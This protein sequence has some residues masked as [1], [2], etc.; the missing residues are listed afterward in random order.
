MRHT[1]T[2]LACLFALALAASSCGGGSDGTTPGSGGGGAGAL[3]IA[4][5]D[6]I[7]EYDI[8]SGDTAPLIEPQDDGAFVLDPAV[9]GD[10]SRIAYIVQPPPRVV[11]ERYDAGSDLWVANRDGGEQQ[12]VLRHTVP[13]QLIRFPQWGADGALY[14]IVQEIED[15]GGVANVAYT[16]QRI[17]PATGERTRLRDGVLAYAVSPDGERVAYAVR[18]ERDRETLYLAALDD[19]TPVEL[20]AASSQLSPFNSPRFSPDGTAVAFAAADQALAPPTGQ[21]LASTRPLA[22]PARTDGLPE[23]IWT[24]DVAGGQP[25]LL[26]DLKEDLPALS[27]NGDGSRLY[28]LGVLGLYE[29]NVHSGANNVIGPGMFHGQMAWSP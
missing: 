5:G 12:L 26:A 28:V 14:A 8:A 18:T 23:D 21:R 6:S 11:G 17:D 3:I 25:R 2:L 4:R 9:S 20:V 13:N 7:V 16:L 10:G 22:A 19:G 24:V 1:R 29:V 27:W 15:V